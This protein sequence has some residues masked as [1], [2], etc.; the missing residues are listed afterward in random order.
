MELVHLHNLP[1][2]ILDSLSRSR[3][4][5]RCI[6][7]PTSSLLTGIENPAEGILAAS[8]NTPGQS[9]Y[10]AA[11][12][13][14]L[15]LL[16][17]L[18]YEELLIPC[19]LQ[20][21]F[22]CKVKSTAYYVRK[23]THGCLSNYSGLLWHPVCWVSRMRYCTP[24]KNATLTTADRPEWFTSK[25][26]WQISSQRSLYLLIDHNPRRSSF[27]PPQYR[28]HLNYL[29]IYSPPSWLRVQELHVTS[30]SSWP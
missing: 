19:F 6:D 27:W 4:S 2:T 3:R 29:W 21:C 18:L 30:M 12:I 25:E 23:E 22:S 26:P 11:T 15:I 5:F 10:L 20:K 24:Q 1:E 16:S 7:W 8:V 28:P 13:G 9:A 17:E 14:F